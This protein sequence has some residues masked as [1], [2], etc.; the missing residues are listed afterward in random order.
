MLQAYDSVAINSD[1]E[2][3]GTDQKFNLL[4]GRDMQEMM[5]Q[6]PQHCLL[7]PILVGTDGVSKMSKSLNNSIDV[8][9]SANN[10]FG[11]LMSIND[12][13]IHPYF[14]L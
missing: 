5:G 9:E 6:K 8:S 11:K 7:V 10:M 13:L 12:D 1:V 3:G 14:E 2:F 4:V